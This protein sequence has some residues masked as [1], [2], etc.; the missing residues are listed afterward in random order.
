MA[1][2]V[3][4]THNPKVVGSITITADCFIWDNIL[5]S[6]PRSNEYLAESGFLVVHLIVAAEIVCSRRD[7][8]LSEKRLNS[9][10]NPGWGVDVKSLIAC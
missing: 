2:L 8:R 10:R 4:W 9:T 6:L 3:G 1:Q 5:P 7:L